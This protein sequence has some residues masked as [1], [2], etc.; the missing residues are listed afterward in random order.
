MRKYELIVI[1]ETGEREVHEY[2]NREEAK[3]A[4]QGYETAFGNQISWIGIIHHSVTPTSMT[5]ECQ[6]SNE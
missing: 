1:W 6:H 5:S 2:N 4:E 3:K